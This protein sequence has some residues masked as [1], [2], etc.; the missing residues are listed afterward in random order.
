MEKLTA[1]SMEEI[2][3]AAPQVYTQQPWEKVSKK[4]SFIPTYKVIEDMDKLG[5]KV[6][7]VKSAKHRNDVQKQHGKHIVQFFNPNIVIND[8][9]GDVEA[10]PQCI[11]IN[12]SMGRGVLRFE[13][14][15]FRLVC[16]NGMIV[17]SEDF[18]SYTLRH[19][20]YSF[21]ELQELMVQ[22]VGKLPQVTEKINTYTQRVMSPEEQSEFAK[23]AIQARFGEE[24][25]VSEFEIN[26]VLQSTRKEDN[27]DNL[28]VVF[29]RVQ[30]SLINGGFIATHKSGKS[31]KVRAI[32][33]MLVDVSINQK[34]WEVAESYA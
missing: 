3:Q 7:S 30:E 19:M 4:Y 33:N 8:A 32:K 1:L 24:K 9:N 26:Q 20:G 29:N 14:G 18:G 2:M 23:K 28:W 5:W 13:M 22:I 17:K 10:Y 11:L 12:N 16:S 15:V 21:E 34:L 6:S 27:G 31:K 25:M